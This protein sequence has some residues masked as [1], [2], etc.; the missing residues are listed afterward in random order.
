M[1]NDGL[2]LPQDSRAVKR[3]GSDVKGV[4]LKLRLAEVIQKA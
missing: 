3:E 2:P 1:A 4:F